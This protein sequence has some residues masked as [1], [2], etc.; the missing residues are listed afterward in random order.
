MGDARASSSGNFG[1]GT[2]G[3]AVERSALDEFLADADRGQGRL[4]WIGGEPGIGKTTLV[5]AVAAR[6]AALGFYVAWGRCWARAG[7]PP[8]WPWIQVLRTLVQ[9]EPEPVAARGAGLL[10]QLLPELRPDAGAAN[11]GVGGGD[12]QRFALFD[13][14]VRFVHDTA[15]AHPL[16][17]VFEDLH[18]AD[19]ASLRLL[20]FAARELAAANVMLVATERV[21]ALDDA[22]EAITL[23]EQIRRLGRRF[24]LRG[25]D[26]QDTVALVRQVSGE[27]PTSRLSDAIHDL[28][29][30]HP[31]FVHEIV[32]ALSA[33]HPSGLPADLQV[34]GMA[35]PDGIAESIR[36]QLRPLSR[37][38][39]SVVEL[40]AVIGRD[41]DAAVV[42]E[43]S[44]LG[45]E[46]LLA[47]LQEGLNVGLI[48]MVAGVSGRYSFRHALMRETIE[49]DLGAVDRP[50]RHHQVG[51]AMARVYEREP[52][53]HAAEIAHHFV[54]A[55]MLGDV[56]SAADWSIAAGRQAMQCL[57]F[58]EAA[59]WYSQALR[60]LDQ[61]LSPDPRRE[62]TA[63]LALGEVQGIAP[64][65]GDA[66]VT[67]EASARLARSLADTEGLALAAL[68]YADRGLGV[69][70]GPADAR[71]IELVDEALT[72]LPKTDGALRARLLARLGSDLCLIDG[73]RSDAAADEAV[74]IARRVA[75]PGALAAALAARGYVHWRRF[76]PSPAGDAD[77]V[78]AIAERLGDTDTAANGRVWKVIEALHAG[79]RE[80]FE[81]E[82]AAYARFA[83]DLRRPRYRWMASNLGATAALWRGDW[84]GA[85]EYALRSLEL[86]QELGDAQAVSSPLVQIFVLRREQDRLAEEEAR[87]RFFAQRVP[88]SPVPRA[89]LALILAE[90]GRLGEARAEFERLAADDFVSL[91]REFRVG[92]LPFLVETCVRI[93]DRPRAQRLRALLMPLADA[94]LAIG[95]NASLGATSHYLGMLLALL[96]DAAAERW[97]NSALARHSAM[98][99]TPW[100]ARTEVE[101]AAWLVEHGNHEAALERLARAETTARTLEMAA[102]L[103]RISDLRAAATAGRSEGST[104]SSRR[105]VVNTR[106]CRLRLEGDYWFVG[107]SE[108]A[109]RIKNSVG[110]RHLVRLLRAPEREIHVLDLIA[111]EHPPE[112]SQLGGRGYRPRA[113]DPAAAVP[114]AQARTAYRGR[115]SELREA[116]DEAE[117]NNDYERARRL[118]EEV[119][120]LTAELADALG[121]RRAGRGRSPELERAR[122]S[123]TRVIR[124][125]IGRVAEAVPDVGAYLTH[126]I[127]TGTFC[128]YSPDA[129]AP[130]SWEL[131]DVDA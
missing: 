105:A 48:E 128:S 28:T 49:R 6:G 42:R 104:R 27:V 74:A 77:E 107:E 130:M 20:S 123:V 113:L 11:T 63:S 57:A 87:T 38:A 80:A 97:F 99:T 116:A 109:T 65:T 100:L 115:L 108:G 46:A 83:A 7:A 91:L 127:K 82:V 111:A 69:S 72:A 2:I 64:A 3:R 118:N 5:E 120:A 112:A 81:A 70:I 8:F 90:A 39:R 103:R 98:G 4:A 21:P 95:I 50:R 12:D 18:D 30:G 26:L 24:E 102:V 51:R 110:M 119:D 85:E 86:A 36:A 79:R 25:L 15:I 92:V 53:A 88:S 33:A 37:D 94:C 59:R 117:R 61:S 54:E 101:F 60:V 124:A 31:L 29:G 126:T 44:E 22:T 19:I 131:S 17:L 16:L 96:G 34:K 73:Q 56:A 41:F 23:R 89:F 122:V 67:F 66:R 32:R 75:D 93:G 76:E 13:A 125:A 43:A 40:A 121:F 45:G 47:A 84:R 129:R 9:L 10:S 68:G 58:E 55:A 106:G 78:I 14:V 114:D 71:S 1:P 62:L 35:V 52:S